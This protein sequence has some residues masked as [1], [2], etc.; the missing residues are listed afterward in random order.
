MDRA[1]GQLD[2]TTAAAVDEHLASCPACRQEAEEI[3]ETWS[4]LGGLEEE[5]SSEAMR[6]RFYTM[7]AE[8]QQAERRE[9]WTAWLTGWW[10]RQP[11]W[12]AAIAVAALA[13]GMWAGPRLGLGNSS[14]IQE[15]RAEMQSMTRAVTLSLL[16]HQ[17]ATER[18]RAVSLSHRQQADTEVTRALLRVVNTDQSV[19]V[20]LAALDVLS[21]L[22]QRPDVRSGLLDSLPH[23]DSPTMQVAMAE[24]LLA[25]DGPRSETAIRE[26]LDD[27]DLNEGVRGYIQE[28]MIKRGNQI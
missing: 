11:A 24:V 25:M 8:T 14:E 10:P 21:E 22:V 17:S 15:L 6:S 3:E 20:R 13:I 12:Q 28:T 18:L 2:E 19:N 1:G 5:K 16:E 26:L 7:L 27:P 9:R 4:L 23:Q